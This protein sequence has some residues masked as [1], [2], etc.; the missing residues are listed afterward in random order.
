MDDKRRQILNNARPEAALQRRTS[1]WG[2]KK[3]RRPRTLIKLSEKTEPHLFELANWR[4][5]S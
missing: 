1:L 2:D 5:A 4:E 3:H